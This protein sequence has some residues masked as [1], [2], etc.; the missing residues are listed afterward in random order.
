MSIGIEMMTCTVRNEHKR[1]TR[2]DYGCH[3]NPIKWLTHE[4]NLKKIPTI[5][6]VNWR[7]SSDAS[8]HH[9]FIKIVFIPNF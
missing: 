9:P 8:R 7:L 3:P 2:Y 4:N 6:W 5:G 1:E